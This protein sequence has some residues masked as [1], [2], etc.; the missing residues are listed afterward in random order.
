MESPQEN[1][2]LYDQLTLDKGC[3]SSLPL[4]GVKIASSTNGLEDLD[5]YMQKKKM[6]HDD[7]LT[8]YTIINSRWIKD[9]SH[10]TIKVLEDNIGRKKFRYSMQQYFH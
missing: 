10:T 8:P 1:P 2:C 3:K 7:Q 5:S 6:K 4:N 9:L